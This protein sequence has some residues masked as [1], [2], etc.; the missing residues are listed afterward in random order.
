[1][2]HALLGTRKARK[3]ERE[4]W[5]FGYPI[6]DTLGLK[7]LAF[8]RVSE[9]SYGQRKLVEVGRALAAQPQ[10]LLLDEP[11]SGLGAS[12]INDFIILLRK[13]MGTGL[14]IIL[15]EHHMDVVKS[16]SDTVTVLD[17]GRVIAGGDYR[18]VSQNPKV[19]EAYLGE[20]PSV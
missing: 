12:E 18:E 11:T 1:M 13:V 8:K 2:V 19:A 20:V 7:D 4:K 15:V 17:E 10:L 16:I 6:I 9:L 5:A 3:S 14:T